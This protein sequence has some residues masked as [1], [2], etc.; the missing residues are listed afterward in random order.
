M[1]RQIDT[2]NPDGWSDEDLVF[3]A[4]RDLIPRDR[5][6]LQEKAQR[7]LQ[8]LAEPTPLDQLANTG[9]VNTAGLTKEEYERAVEL[10][11]M[12]Q[13]GELEVDSDEEDDDDD[14]EEEDYDEGWNNDERRAELTRRGLVTTG[15]KAEL[16]ARL[17][18]S[19][20]DELEEGDRKEGSD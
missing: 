13:N 20:N 10:L 1:S 16:I 14:E 2:K 11:R 17:L 12:E 3:A 15:D 8:G 9:T 6:D 19:D 7:L 5:Y 18:R 4:Q